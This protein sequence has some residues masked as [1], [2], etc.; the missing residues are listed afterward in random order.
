MSQTNISSEQD[1]FLNDSDPESGQSLKAFVSKIIAHWYLFL[2][3]V[4]LCIFL[5]VLYSKFANVSYLIYAKIMVKDEKQQGGGMK[6]LMADMELGSLLGG[7]TDSESELEILTSRTLMTK[8]VKKLQLNVTHG[9]K[10]K[11]RALEV[12]DS[13]IP[14]TVSFV[15]QGDSLSAME[16]TIDK[17]NEHQFRFRNNTE[18]IDIIGSFGK[19]IVLPQYT[20]IL[21]KKQNF[22]L[23]KSFQSF[24]FT[25]TLSI[26]SIQTRTAQLLSGI[27][28]E[29]TTKQ[30]P[31]ISLSLK[32]AVP[33]KG[34]QILQTL[35]DLYMKDNL[36][37]KQK[38]ADSTL[39]FIDAQLAGVSTGLKGIEGQIEEFKTDNELADMGAQ[40]Q[41]L[42][43]NVSDYYVKLNAI[44]M[45]L[46]LVKKISSNI[47][48][49]K[50]KQ[51]IPNTLNVND[52]VFIQYAGIYNQLILKRQ[53]EL[54]N[55]TE[56]NPLVKNLDIQI[57]NARVN[58]LR[59]FEAFQ[60]NLFETKKQLLKENNALIGQVRKV[61]KKERVYLDYTRQQNLQQQLYLYLLQKRAETAI[62]RTSTFGNSQIIDGAKSA[63]APFT[64]K[65]KVI[66]LG[67]LLAGLILPFAYLSLR[68]MLN[69]RIQTKQDITKAV[70][71]P[72]TGEIGHNPDG[73]NLVIDAKSRSIIS[74]Q[75]RA[76]RT[77]LQFLFSGDGSK[78]VLITSSMSG[79]GKSF[80]SLNLATAL[81]ITEKKVVLL[82]FDLRKPR[83]SANIGMDNKVGFSNYIKS[84]S[85]DI[86]NVIK[87]TLIHPNVYILPSGPIPPN[88]AEL[89]L[90]EKV[91]KMMEELK[92]QF[93]YIIIDTAPVGLVADALLLE[94]T[95][96]LTL[97]V[98]RQKVTYKSQLHII[99]E[100]ARSKKIRKASLVVNDISS[101][102]S[103]Y[104]GYSYGG[105]GYSY[106]YGYGGY[107]DQQAKSKWY[108]IWRNNR[109]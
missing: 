4:T 107:V 47:N 2:I 26:Q 81:A 73:Q 6:G 22:K 21:H 101:E 17:V 69:T 78:V 86:K 39:N 16:Y 62:S 19:P 67:G 95:A 82:E 1:P 43:K 103:S 105:Y 44:D 68:D 29:T 12:E 7:S 83:L 31:V 61:P 72:I 20:I 30:G 46:S 18:D 90:D 71:L 99:D 98:V 89:L 93:D 38:M 80:I 88:P 64:P 108:Q 97:Y 50:N 109:S 79:E 48:N 87:Q 3:G 92:G 37:D 85:I 35:I 52:P 65:K 40:S 42:V 59:G 34:E 63:D 36:E 8:V 32:Y 28:A 27:N 104:Y 11:L 84:D 74:E 9:I 70:N 66:Y 14:Y 56:D 25:F 57:E 23:D 53:A 75:F 96:D 13:A 15:S 24:A 106:G 54:L 41:E 100:L 45:Q 60:D 91:G 58:L 10:G 102:A 77:N 55:Y 76:L 51:I 5:S 33:G 94:S 49:P